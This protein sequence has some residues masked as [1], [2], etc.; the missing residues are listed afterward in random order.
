[1]AS[2]ETTPDGGSAP[3]TSVRRA[4]AVAGLAQEP[5]TGLFP[6]G[7]AAAAAAPA[8]PA[9]A[10]AASAGTAE[11]GRTAARPAAA[12]GETATA[13]PTVSGAA[14]ATPAAAPQ[15]EAA[16]PA[17]ATAPATGADTEGAARTRTGAVSAVRA[18]LATATRSTGPG[19]GTGTGANGDGTPPGR[20]KK[21]LIAAAALGGLVLIAVPFLITGPD[22]EERKP[23]VAEGP[24]GSV[25][26]PD[27][28]DPGLVPGEERL[29]GAAKGVPARKAVPPAAGKGGAAGGGSSALGPVPGPQEAGAPLPGVAGGAGTGGAADGVAG[30]AT[31]T[32]GKK[33]AGAPAAGNP[34]PPAGPA[35]KPPA[36]PGKKAPS[37]PAPSKPKPAAKPPAP[38]PVTYSHLIGPGCDT[39]GFAAG[40]RYDKKGKDRWRG[41]R[42][43][44]TG[45]GCS[46]F[47][48]SVPNS[49]RSTDDSW[50]QWKFTT[51]KVTKGVCAVQ[52]YIPNVKDITRVGGNPAYYTV[53]RAFTQKSSNVLGTFSINQTSRLGQWVNAGSYAVSGG[54]ISVVLGNRGSDSGNRHAAAAPVRVNC[55][56]S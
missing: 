26:D 6:A 27:G 33:A 46:G 9:A 50:A 56:A 8:A 14:A 20:P 7:A 42:G 49:D 29:P 17:A 51:G 28:D 11:T 21:P 4:A 41:S 55:T 47:Y 18:R 37:A 5:T 39:P 43:S 34:K 32:N 16:A 52:V 38:T 13:V 25:M 40:G 44:T 48:F 10:A 23:V 1:M 30:A 12:E 53:Y 22:E 3:D 31:G 35:K 45:Y 15:P 19:S 2:R 24:P 36:V 54:K